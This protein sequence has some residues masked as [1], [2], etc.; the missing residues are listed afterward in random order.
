MGAYLKIKKGCFKEN[1]L[2]N[3][4]LAV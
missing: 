1:S 2:F 3:Q 4:T